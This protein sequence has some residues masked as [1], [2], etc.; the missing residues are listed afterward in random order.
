LQHQGK[1][2]AEAASACLSTCHQ[3]LYSQYAKQLLSYCDMM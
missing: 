1:N 2:K 3:L